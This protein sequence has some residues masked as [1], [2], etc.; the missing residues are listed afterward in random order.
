MLVLRVAAYLLL[1]ALPGLA[2]AQDS[3]AVAFDSGTGQVEVGGPYAGVE[4]HA[5]PLPARISFYA[6]VANSIDPSTDYWRRGEARPY[7]ATVRVDGRA[8]T[9]GTGPWAYRWTPYRVVFRNATP[10]YG[11]TID[12][13]FAADLPVVV[14]RFALV[15]R[16]GRRAVFGLDTSLLTALRTSHTYATRQPAQTQY[17]DGGATYLASFDAADTD[18]ADVFVLNAGAA[19]DGAHAPA[20]ATAAFTYE[21]TLAPGDSLVVVQ[22]IGTVRRAESAR[23][24]QRAA[25]TWAAEVEAYESGIRTAVRD[26]GRMDLPDPVLMETDRLARAL[27]RAD[28]HHLDGEI[29]PMPSPAEYNFFFTHDLLLTDLGAVFFDLD[30]VRS[31]LRYVQSLVRADSVLPH[32]RYWKDSTYVV[33]PANADNWNHLWVILLAASYLKHSG[34]T[35]TVEA[36]LPTLEK[37][38]SLMLANERDG[39]M[40]A[41]RPDWWDIG[42]VP[43]PRAYLTALAIRAVDAYAYV[44]LRLGRDD[45]ALPA[46]AATALRMRRAL[47]ERLWDA[48]ARYLLNGLDSTTIDRHLYTG[49]L[50]AAAYGLLDAPRRDALLETARREL[51][52]PNVGVRNAMPMDF[53]GLTDVYRFQPG[54]VGAPGLYMNG[55]VWP[56]GNAWYALGLIAAG[57]PDAA[58]DVLARYLTVAGVRDSPNG[59]PAFYEYRNAAAG[60]P[61]YG[62]VDKPT[63]LWAGG[64]FLHVLYQLAGVRETPWTLGFSPDL[65]TG[66]DA[67]RYDLAVFGAQSRVS[68]S[69]T[70]RTFRRITIDGVD[71]PSAI[72]TGP[73]ERIDLERGLPEAPYLA[74]ATALV[75]R[76]ARAGE[77]LEVGVRGVAGQS[78][79]AVVVGPVPFATARVDGRAL[80]SSAVTTER[81]DGAFQ[82]R[83]DWALRSE[84][85]V[86]TVGP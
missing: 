37:S 17:L 26:R 52:D 86:L 20:D 62:A 36:M 74:E 85:A 16:T 66:Y 57:Q 75:G 83:I 56:Q 80:P 81:L 8:D 47:P 9:L 76:V 1:A 40:V 12:Y 41:E 10:D 46:H 69:G 27:L 39:L 68:W 28:R 5:R 33:E 22:V 14:V 73:A 7:A 63:F 25:E 21:Q 11:A 32:A 24:R 48:D 60:S 70:G 50:L 6:P 35:A 54:E 2:R 51:L 45:P 15:N 65:P 49:S 13:R 72:L 19:P 18:S 64:W 82:S 71:T 43:G 29:V 78:V 79:E 42:H 61:N 55:G 59:Q 84:D 53:E 23:V 31:D 77:G 3:L 58:R 67:I 34:D 44:R 38:L 4:F 30:R